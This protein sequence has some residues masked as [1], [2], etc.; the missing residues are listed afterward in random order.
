MPLLNVMVAK[1]GTDQGVEDGQ[2]VA[3]VIHHARK[4][5]TEMRFALGILVPLR[6][7]GWRNFN[8]AAQLFRGVS[9]QEQ[10]VKE[11]RFALRKFQ[12]RNKFTSRHHWSDRRHSENAVYR[13]P[14]P[15]QVEPSSPCREPVKARVPTATEE[16][17]TG[18]NPT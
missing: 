7:D 13:K 8:V 3:A 11:G 6:Q 14:C 5:V 16:R 1:V 12:V 18:S 17:L 9:A 10:P 2:N 4:Y 15:R